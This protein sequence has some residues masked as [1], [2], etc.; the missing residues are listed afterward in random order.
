MA[1]RKSKAQR[2]SER[3]AEHKLYAVEQIERFLWKHY[4]L[5]L[6]DVDVFIDS[7]KKYQRVMSE[8]QL[9]D[10]GNKVEGI[11]LSKYLMEMSK[12]K[13]LIYALRAAVYYAMWYNRKPYVD[14]H[15]EFEAELK[16]KGLEEAST[17]GVTEGWDDLHTYICSG[18]RQIK[19]LV[20]ERIPK[21]K[22]P[23][24]N[25]YV[26]ACC[27]KPFIYKGKIKYTNKKLRELK[28]R[29]R[30][31]EERRS[32]SITHHLESNDS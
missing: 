30:R 22:C 7:D 18:C 29:L 5:T 2:K 25:K 15:P 23:V 24:E 1:N 27:E 6:R 32:R 20:R 31:K 4:R 9:S 10:D 16:D 26:T 14:G 21:K 13:V 12:E 19:F 11:I 3:I 8:L 28:E 17:G